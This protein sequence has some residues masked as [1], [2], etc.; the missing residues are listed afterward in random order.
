VLKEQRRDEQVRD[1]APVEST[2]VAPPSS[3]T[4]FSDAGRVPEVGDGF[5]PPGPSASERAFGNGPT[6]PKEL[7][8]IVARGDVSALVQMVH[9]YPTLRAPIMAAIGQT[10]GAGV[11]QQVGQTAPKTDETAAAP[12]ERGPIQVAD[13]K[14][15]DRQKTAGFELVARSHV[16]EGG[17]PDHVKLPSSLVDA[18]E[19]MWRDTNRKDGSQVEQGGNI[20]RTYGGD[21][22]VRRGKASGEDEFEPD[23]NDV[24]MGDTLV[25]VTHTHPYGKEGYDYGTFSDIDLANFVDQ[26]EPIKLLR[27]GGQTY[28][29]A[30]T[31]EFDAIVKKHEKADTLLELKKAMI[32]TFNRAYEADLAAKVGFPSALESGVLAVCHKFHLIYYWGQGQELHRVK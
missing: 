7:V 31:K 14:Q 20:V 9:A 21:Y 8:D 18:L 25:G 29:L 23:W 26:D 17:A 6:L 24:G 27:S 15:T 16:R 1:E 22:E 5:A 3:A 32:D 13:S 4:K 10:H 28:M 12:A 11:V 30:R 19:K 2:A